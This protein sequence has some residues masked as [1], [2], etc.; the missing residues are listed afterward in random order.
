MKRK[1]FRNTSAIALL[2]VV[3]IS[4]GQK[5]KP[6]EVNQ[7][8]D[9]RIAP[10]RIGSESSNTSSVH[11]IEIEIEKIDRA[12]FYAAKHADKVS[13]PVEKITDFK[14]VQ[15][16]LSGIVDFNE[17]EGYLGVKRIN[18]RNGTSSD[19]QKDFEEYAFVAYFPKED[20]LLCEGGHTIDV[21][22]DLGTAKGTYDIGNPAFTTTSPSGK[23]RL[24]KVFE[25][26]ACFYH[27][28]QEKKGQKFQK[29][30]ELN[31]IFEKKTNKWLCTI[32]KEFWTDDLTLFFGLVTQYK[33]GGNEYEYYKVNL[34]E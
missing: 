2:F 20:I 24:N 1:S 29:V 3:L 33:E 26:Q 6:A 9:K 8:S 31:E 17:M 4:C 25:G 16:R 11:T 12:Q 21:S 32:E 5:L 15:E 19:E 22:F 18:F 13:K 23:Y 30:V 28:I 34:M 14:I 7:Q 27:F 10:K